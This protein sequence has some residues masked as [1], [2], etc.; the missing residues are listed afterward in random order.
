MLLQLKSLTHYIGSRKLLDNISFTINKKQRVGIIGRN[1]SGK[2]TL[3]KLIKG[4]ERPYKGEI[5]IPENVKIGYLPQGFSHLPLETTVRD[6]L[7]EPLEN[8]VNHLKTL[9]KLMEK[10]KISGKNI[11]DILREYTH[12]YGKFEQIGG[13]CYE[14]KLKETFSLLHMD[15]HITID[16]DFYFSK[17]SG[18]QKLKLGFSR[19][20]ASEPDLLILDEPTNY[21]D[22]DSL[23]WLENFLLSFKGGLL[24]VSHDRKFLDKISTNIMELSV[25]NGMMK[26]YT[27]NYSSYREQ[28]EQEEEKHRREYGEQQERIA[29][30]REDIGLMKGYA[31]KTELSTIHFHPRAIAKKVARKAKVRERKLERMLSEENRIDKPWKMEEVRIKLDNNTKRG[32]SLLSIR[33]LG[34]I[35]PDGRKLF[36]GVNMEFSCGHRIAVMGGNGTG[37]STFMRILAE[38]IAPSWGEIVKWPNTMTAYLPQDEA[39]GLNLE[40][41]VFEEFRDGLA[42]EEGQARTFLHRMLFKGEDVFKRVGDLSY[43][44]RIKLLLAKLMASGANALLLDEP[45]GHLDI[46]SMERLEE[47]LKEFTGGLMV[48]THDR[49]FMEK[50]NFSDIYVLSEGR[51]SKKL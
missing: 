48:I 45:T 44:E 8:Y 16:S 18:G 2:S 38:K 35:L 21:L 24:F 27:G 50:L 29:E 10:D 3:F 31:M 28:K 12:I 23:L 9:E 7:F 11:E 49:Y 26:Y 34:Y 47:A 46:D 37:K 5:I 25:L 33:N 40:R 43:G 41:T 15:N 6:F 13:Y 22:L 4:E 14:D 51:L 32:K 20:L 19:I 39:E 42:M 30:I 1:G 36:D 17:L